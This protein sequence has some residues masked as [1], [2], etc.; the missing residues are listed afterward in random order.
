M[1]TYK[2]AVLIIGLIMLFNLSLPVF[3]TPAT[4]DFQ[5]NRASLKGLQGIA[6]SVILP[7]RAEQIGLFERHLISDIEPQLRLAGIKVMTKE[8]VLNVKGTPFIEVSITTFKESQGMFSYFIS[9]G[10]IQDVSLGRDPLI[11]LQ[12]ITW[13]HGAL[14][15]GDKTNV[16]NSIKDLMNKFI[17]AYLSVNPKS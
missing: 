7:D 14:G 8:E 15:Y 9:I 5:G 17:D 13:I 2:R 1:N 11:G 3:A 4:R 6:V 12:G 10:F 16:R